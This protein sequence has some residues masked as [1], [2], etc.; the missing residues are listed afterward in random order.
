MLVAK[1]AVVGG[2]EWLWVAFVV[3][4]IQQ[5]TSFVPINAYTR[6]FASVCV[7]VFVTPRLPLVASV[8]VR[9]ATLWCIVISDQKVFS[10]I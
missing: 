6:S 5:K 2:F 8:V 9:F 3:G 4:R 1:V 7:Y 10:L